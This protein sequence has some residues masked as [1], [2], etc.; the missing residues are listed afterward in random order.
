MEIVNEAT[1]KFQGFQDELCKILFNMLREINV[2]ELSM[3]EKISVLNRRPTREEQSSM[4][5]DFRESYKRIVYDRCTEKLLAKPY[6]MSFY[7]EIT[8]AWADEGF[9]DCKVT[10]QMTVPKRAVIE[11]RYKR[12]AQDCADKFT[13]IKSGEKWLVDAHNWWTDYDSVWHRGHI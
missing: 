12:G 3:L 8:Y 4:W 7:S 10:F 13:L 9:E 1:E 2:L 6:G 5:S 11:A